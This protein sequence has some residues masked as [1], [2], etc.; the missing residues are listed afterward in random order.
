M[1]DLARNIKR[2]ALV[3]MLGFALLCVHLGY[4]HVL[5]APA[6]RA[7][8]HNT[9][10][11]DRLRSIVPG[12]LYDAD[13][14]LLMGVAGSPGAWKRTY[15][16]GRYVCHLTGYNE[17]SGLQ[18]GLRDAFLGIGTYEKPWAE[19]IE[20]PLQGND[21]V[22]TV[23]LDAQELATRLLRGRR[24][25][26]VALSAH[27]GA[28]LTLVSA[29]AYDPAAILA[30]DWD[31]QLFQED[32]DKPE[33]N[34]ALQ[35]LYPPGSVLK[36]LTAALVLDLGRVRP[37][38]TFRCTG[39]YEFEGA[40]IR[41]PRAHGTVDLA[42]AL[43]VSCNTTFAQLARQFTAEEFT[44]YAGRFRLLTRAQLP[45]PSS[46]GRLGDFSGPRGG[47]LLSETAF[48]QGATLVTPLAIARLTLA[49]AHG[50]G[51]LEPYL[52]EL[53][54]GPGGRVVASARPREVGQAVSAATAST[55][56]GMMRGVVEEG[57]GR[58]AQL[59]GINVA[60][61]TGSAENPHG[62]AHS[63]FTCFAPAEDPAVVVTVVVENA[64]AGSEAAA[65]IAR[66]V[67]ERLLDR[68]AIR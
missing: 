8:P 58:V 20:G 14:E 66:E 33:Y 1:D 6:L 11:Q 43:A 59:R 28:V 36:I 37:D 41:C 46:E 22:L 51:V 19:F 65:P 25:A 38:T 23:D 9:R 44:E 52:V 24:G 48:G 35:G 15:P 17:R 3:P 45:L 67:L 49:L 27:T 54:R 10:A 57:T 2:V 7:D 26:V 63:W 21:V 47:V 13:A 31:Y 34:R 42:E 55:V 62:A 64:G 61:K 4:W 32:P 40:T 68:E 29:P 60:G 30:S 18:W 53:V 5:R 16:A 50:G 56:A 12:R 39:S